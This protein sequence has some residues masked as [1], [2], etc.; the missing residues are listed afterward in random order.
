MELD[1]HQISREQLIGFDATSIDR[2]ATSLDRLVTQN[3]PEFF[4]WHTAEDELHVFDK[5][6][7]GLGLEIGEAGAEQWK[8]LCADWLRRK[9]WTTV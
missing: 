6:A 1:T 5:G 9:G 8:A 3:S 4:V 7:H 2:A